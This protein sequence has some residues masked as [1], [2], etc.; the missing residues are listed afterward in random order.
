MR[1]KVKP[2]ECTGCAL[3]EL[4]CGYHWDEA[5]SLISSSIMLYRAEEKKDYMGVI[6]KTEEDLFIAPDE[7]YLM[8]CR[9]G[10]GF[11]SWDIFIS[12]RKEDG[13]WTDARNMGGEINTSASEVYPVVTPDG[14]YFF[15]SSSRTTHDD[16]SE[17]PITLDEKLKILNGP[18]N[19][20][21]DIYWVDARFIEEL[22]KK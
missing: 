16:Y 1:I 7:S 8:F 3:C 10:D 20:Q 2:L 11:G 21:A 18:G 6:V 9:R 19:G 15:F 17:T 13:S 14:R 5:F 22:K 4:A 12:F